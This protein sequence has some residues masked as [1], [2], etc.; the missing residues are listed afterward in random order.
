[1]QIG[2]N[3]QPRLRCHLPLYLVRI[4]AKPI[5]HPPLEVAHGNTEILQSAHQQLVGRM[6]HQG[7]LA[8]LQGRSHRQ[9]IRHRR[10][11]NRYHAFWR[12]A[13][14]ARQPLLQRL[15]TVERGTVDFQ[16]FQLDRQLGQRIA[17]DAAGRQIVVGGRP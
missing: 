14:S 6:L 15:I 12:D 16:V 5:L 8:R 4:D 11:R 7:F 9:M 2:K 10:S 3:D 17:H 1:M 13:V